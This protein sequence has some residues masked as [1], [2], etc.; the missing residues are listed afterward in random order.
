MACGCKGGTKA[1]MPTHQVIYADRSVRNYLTQGEA[2]A[3]VRHAARTANPA[4][5]TPPVR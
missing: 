5:Y 1:A 2:E 3:A 4:T